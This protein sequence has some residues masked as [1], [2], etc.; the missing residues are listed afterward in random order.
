MMGKRDSYH[1]D[2]PF[3]TKHKNNRRW[4]QKKNSFLITSITSYI[5]IRSIALVEFRL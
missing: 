2:T 4:K 1:E 5:Y 3:V